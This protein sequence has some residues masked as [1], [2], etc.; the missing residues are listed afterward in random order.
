[1]E[2]SLDSKSRI[3][4]STIS[5][6]LMIFERFDLRADFPAS[7]SLFQSCLQNEYPDNDKSFFVNMCVAIKMNDTP[8]EYRALRTP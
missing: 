2:D 4:K 3:K 6:E 7:L 5:R 8:I 1:V